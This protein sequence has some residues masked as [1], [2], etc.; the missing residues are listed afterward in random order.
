M[1][2]K[3]FASADRNNKGLGEKELSWSI[4]QQTVQIQIIFKTIFRMW[5][6]YE[7]RREPLILTHQ[8][9]GASVECKRGGNN[10][11]EQ[12]YTVMRTSSRHCSL[13]F[14][15]PPTPKKK[16]S[17]PQHL[18]LLWLVTHLPTDSVQPWS[19]LE[20][21]HDLWGRRLEQGDAIWWCA[22]SVVRCCT[23]HQLSAIILRIFLYQFSYF[24]FPD[25]SSQAF[26]LGIFGSFCFNLVSQLPYVFNG[27]GNGEGSMEMSQVLFTILLYYKK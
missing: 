1:V 4:S 22:G 20:I 2:H 15:F 27:E 6:V 11:E 12:I 10:V 19:A 17:F 5:D 3:A 13:W 21:S 14:L 16:I 25:C 24:S 9:S 23:G 7:M 18:N 26:V 8:G